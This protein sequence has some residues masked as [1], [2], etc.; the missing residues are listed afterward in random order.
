M[1]QLNWVSTHG[2]LSNTTIASDITASLCGLL[3]LVINL[4]HFRTTLAWRVGSQNCHISKRVHLRHFWIQRR[5]TK[6]ITCEKLII[7]K[8]FEVKGKPLSLNRQS[9][10]CCYY[11]FFSTE[12]MKRL[13]A[14]S[15]GK[16][17][18]SM[19]RN[20]VFGLSPT[21]EIRQPR[22]LNVQLSWWILDGTWCLV[23]ITPWR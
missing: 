3:N 2:Y 22:L 8:A 5:W 21:A 9:T 1:G 16:V 11:V 19:F 17:Q 6:L 4:R 10:N 20:C 12:T 15:D 7:T 13:C 14:T 23:H 18:Q